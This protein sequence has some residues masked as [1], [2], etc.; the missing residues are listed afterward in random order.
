[1]STLI[2]LAAL[3]AFR[4]PF[5]NNVWRCGLVSKA[6]ISQA[7]QEGLGYDYDQWQAIKEE[8]PDQLPTVRQHAAR[9]AYLVKHG[10]EDSIDIDVGV[11][12]LGAVSHW[13]YGDGNHRICAAIIRGDTFISAEISGDIDYAE[14]LFGVKIMELDEGVA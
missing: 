9:I 13:P 2:P 11:P 8:S 5:E 4:S 12:S 1:M 7:L 6:M 14:H 10:W 3:D